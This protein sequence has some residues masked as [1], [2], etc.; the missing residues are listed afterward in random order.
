MPIDSFVTSGDVRISVRDWCGDGT[1]LLL[2]PGGGC[3]IEDLALMVPVLRQSFHVYAMDCRNHGLSSDAAWTWDAVLDD[4]RAVIAH[5]GLDRPVVAG[6]SLGGILSAMLATSDECRAAINIDGHGSGTVDLY[7][8]LTAEEVGDS[9]LVTE[10]KI[11]Q[12]RAMWAPL[13]TVET[14]DVLKPA[15]IAQLVGVGFSQQQAES[16]IER[17]LITDADGN[18]WPRTG[19]GSSIEI[20]LLTQG[21]D[22]FATYRDTKVPLLV[23]N[24]TKDQPMP[25]A[26][27]E[28][29]ARY[30][31]L[32]RGLTLALER[33]SAENALVSH[34]VVDATHSLIYEMPELLATQITEFAA[35]L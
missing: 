35:R 25:G 10:D 4:I 18:V 15:A 14:V 27:D 7:D 5:F 1:P 2:I 24:A 13:A 34:H 17:G 30:Q 9:N 20:A 21:A 32:R 8:G 22:F 3:N 29:V 6:H 19:L 11:E 31:A 12:M 16:R 33:L 23:Y 28:D 26:S